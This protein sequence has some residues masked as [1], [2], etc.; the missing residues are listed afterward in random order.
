MKYLEQKDPALHVRVKGII[1][2]C[3]ERNRNKEPGYESVTGT[4]GISLLLASK[5]NNHRISFVLLSRL[6][7]VDNQ[8]HT[9]C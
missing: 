1:K 5:L 8:G 3:A 6:H 4:Y 2:E 9:I 7:L